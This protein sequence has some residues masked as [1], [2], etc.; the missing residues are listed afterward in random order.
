M[1]EVIDSYTREAGVRNLEREIGSVCRAVAVKVAEG[2]A[3]D[4]ERI[5]AAQVEEV[6]GPKKY[7][8]EVAERVGEPG[9][10]TGLAWTAV[11]GDILFIEATQMPGKGKLTLTGQLGDVM[12]ESVT[13]ALSF[14]RGRAAA[15]GLDPGNFLENKDLHVHVPAGAVPKDGPSAGVTIFTALTSLFSGRRV[16]PRTAMTGEATLRGRVMPVGGIKA[17]VLA[18]H[19]AGITRVVLPARNGRDLGRYFPE[20][21]EDRHELNQ[22]LVQ[23]H[24][25]I[26]HALLSAMGQSDELLAA[27]QEHETARALVWQG[28]AIF[29]VAAVRQLLPPFYA[30]GD[31]RR[32]A[33]YAVVRVAVSTAVGVS[34]M[35][36]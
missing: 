26:G 12:K 17:K 13:A 29:T 33:I 20:L 36:W 25:N 24:D 1:F 8:S 3:K 11:G 15:L 7:V 2:Q 14:V 27:V 28:A 32:P 31:T 34:L 16:R 5:E 22:M 19:R 35:G 21:I 23:W 18:A 30:L 10:A 4:H 6:L 9:V